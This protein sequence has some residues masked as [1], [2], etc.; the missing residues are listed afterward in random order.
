LETLHG[1]L[2]GVLAAAEHGGVVVVAKSRRKLPRQGGSCVLVGGFGATKSLDELRD[3]GCVSGTDELHRVVTTPVV[4]G[5][6]RR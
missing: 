1:S 6:Q 4:A 5:T 2:E 3:G